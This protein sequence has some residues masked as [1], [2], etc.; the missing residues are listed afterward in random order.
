[1]WN[2]GDIFEGIQSL[3]EQIVSFFQGLFGN[4]F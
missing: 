4:I 1:M 2:P 3:I